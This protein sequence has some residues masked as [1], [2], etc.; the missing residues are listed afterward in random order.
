MLA[1]LAYLRERLETSF[2][3]IPVGVCALCGA[4]A[5]ATLWA[6]R[7][8]TDFYQ[9]LPISDMS[10]D[11]ARQLLGVIAGSVISVG[12]VAFSITMVALT[13]TSGQYGPKIVRR[14]LEDVGAKICL[15]LFLG[16]FI[17]ALVALAGLAATDS[18]RLIVAIALALALLA[19]LSFIH[20]IHSTAT[21][22]QADKIIERLGGQL[23]EALSAVCDGGQQDGRQYGTLGWRRAARGRRGR[24]IASRAAGYVETIDY[25]MLVE[26]CAKRDCQLMLRVRPGDLVLDGVCL[27]KVFGGAPEAVEA[28][29]ESLQDSIVAGPVRTPAQDPEFPITQ[30]HQ[31]VARALSPGVNDPGTAITCIDWFSLSLVAV[32]DR[33]LPGCVFED[34]DGMPRLLARGQT[35]AQ[36]IEAIYA[37]LREMSGASRA[38][39]ARLLESLGWLSQLTVRRD[40][41]ALLA[42]HGQRIWHAIEADGL[43][44]YDLVPLRSRYRKL[45]ALSTGLPP[46]AERGR[47]RV[48][49]GGA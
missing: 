47:R 38:V 39:R 34:A 31:L 17:F 42:Q 18:P 11:S 27:F 33:D 4:A 40:R 26:W 29:F 49:G 3:L 10:L 19:L 32:I 7:A 21:D 46:G 30:L 5:L 8:L 48:P 36:L 9:L 25:R 23:R 1:K 28:D 6:D 45:L 13:L 44:P 24:E 2:W 14:F 22:L 12:G 15:G 16:T 43:A 41:L 35:F 37:P 20:F